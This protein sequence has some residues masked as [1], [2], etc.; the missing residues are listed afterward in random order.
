[1]VAEMYPGLDPGLVS[2]AGRSV[3]AHVIAMAERGDIIADGAIEA[4]AEY[5]K[6]G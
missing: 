2:A 6:A 5:R 4:D 3:F 1:M